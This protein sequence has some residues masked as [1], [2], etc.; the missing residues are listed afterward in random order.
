M[1]WNPD[2]VVVGC[3][4][5]S[6]SLECELGRVSRIDLNDSTAYTEAQGWADLS[7]LVVIRPL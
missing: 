6:K 1:E 2:P 3:Y 7:D 5:W 4:V